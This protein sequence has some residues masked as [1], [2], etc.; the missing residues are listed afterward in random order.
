[1]ASFSRG[2]LDV[3]KAFDFFLHNELF[4][5]VFSTFRQEA[6]STKMTLSVLPS[7]IALS[8]LRTCSY[9]LIQSLTSLNC[10]IINGTKN[11]DKKNG[12]TIGHILSGVK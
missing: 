12:Q 11:R 6:S 5:S 10:V 9:F 1:M 2:I 4:I 7:V 8:S 3:I